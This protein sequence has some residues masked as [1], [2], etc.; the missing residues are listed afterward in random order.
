MSARLPIAALLAAALA[1]PATAQPMPPRPG[2]TRNIVAACPSRDPMKGWADPAPPARIFGNTY[3]VGTCGI[4]SLLVETSAGL[5]LLD[6]GVPEAA[7]LVLANIRKLGF[8]PRAI[9]WILVTHE[10]Y[11][12]AGALAAI[13]RESGARIAAGP[14]QGKVLSTG[15]SDPND[16]QAPLLAKHSIAPLRI[17]QTMLNYGRLTVG[18]VDFTPVATPAH[19]PG[20]TSWTWRDCQGIECRT[21][22]YADSAT[23]IS[24]D[25]YRFSDNPKRIAAVH[26]GLGAIA[27]LPCDIMITPHPSASDLFERM[28]GAKPLVQTGAC[29]AYALASAKRF[30]ERLASENTATPPAK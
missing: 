12:H 13:Q 9:R 8:S 26:T 14:F 22:A 6:G 21:I 4:T 3:Y 15:Q 16:P 28:S 10:H 5:V 20:S 2:A 25:G 19:S 17:A 23:A 27:T 24:A 11:D 18:G 30:D 1:L 7:P 29:R